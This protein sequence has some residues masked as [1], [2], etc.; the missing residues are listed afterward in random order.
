MDSFTGQKPAARPRTRSHSCSVCLEVFT[1]PK[2]LPCCHTFC[3]KCL[4]KTARSAQTRGEITCP[5]CRNTH[6][7]PTGG[8]NEFLTDFME[9]YEIEAAGLK[10]ESAGSVVCGECEESSGPLSSYCTNCRNY[11]CNECVQ[12]HKRVKAYRGHEITSTQEISAATLQSHVTHYCTIH[13]Q[14]ALKLYC[15]TCMRLICRDCTLVEHRQ[16]DYKFV[17]NARKQVEDEL[18]SL[19]SD[20][21]KKLTVFNHNLKEIKKVEEAV[22]GHTQVLKADINY[23]FDKLVQSIEAKCKGLLE[24]A[25]GACQTDLKQVWADK[26]FHETTIAH[27]QSVLRFTEKAHRCTSDSEMILTALHSISQLRVLQ[28]KEWETFKFTDVVRSTPQFKQSGCSVVNEIGSLDRNEL[29]HYDIQVSHVHVQYLEH[30]YGGGH[31]LFS[32]AK[33]GLQLIGGGSVGLLG[34]QGSPRNLG[35]YSLGSQLSITVNVRIPPVTPLVDGRSGAAVSLSECKPPELKAVVHY[36]HSAKELDRTSL[37]INPQRKQTESPAGLY[38]V[39]VC[40]ICSGQH[41]LTLKVGSSEVKCTFSVVG[42]PQNGRKVR[43]GPDWQ[44][45]SVGSGQIGTVNFQPSSNLRFVHTSDLMMDTTVHD[46]VTVTWGD[47]ATTT[48]HKWGRDGKYEI[49]LTDCQYQENNIQFETK[50]DTRETT[51]IW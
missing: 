45:G 22:V 10:S 16:H 41:T 48:Q 7:I 51:H 14:E 37:T 4:E 47:S 17:E 6:L 33:T 26:E 8:L 30:Q 38:G 43:R 3:L 34:R 19:K 46:M 50:N 25:G 49:E 44:H 42:Q 2:V 28:G 9:V 31:G 18:G 40:L 5:Q 20:A 39:N 1:D 35:N 29:P 36:G 24:K 12:L 21:T 23:F 27:I 32:T 15:V 13:K 11:L